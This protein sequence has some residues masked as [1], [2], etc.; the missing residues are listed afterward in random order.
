MN[1]VLGSSGGGVIRSIINVVLIH[2]YI[3]SRVVID[4]FWPHKCT[5]LSCD[6]KNQSHKDSVSSTNIFF[7]DDWLK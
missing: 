6:N 5:V 1:I 7:N 2:F 3:S 4:F